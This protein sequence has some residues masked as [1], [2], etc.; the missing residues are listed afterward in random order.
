MSPILGRIDADHVIGLHVTQL[1]SFPSGDPAELEA[2]SEEEKRLWQGYQWWKTN[3]G[4]YDQLQST[5]PQTLAYALAD[6]PAGLSAWFYDKF[7]FLH[8]ILDNKYYMDKFNEAVF[9]GGARLLGNGLWNVVDGL[10]LGFNTAPGLAPY[11]KTG[12]AQQKIVEDMYF[13]VLKA[14]E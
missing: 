7:K 14:L 6:S 12:K 8:T 9:A 13:E 2:L 1:F 3:L 10:S 11:V 4:A 5:V